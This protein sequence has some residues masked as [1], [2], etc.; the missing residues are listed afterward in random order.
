MFRS[1]LDLH[2]KSCRPIHLVVY[3]LR[4]DKR[5][6]STQTCRTTRSYQKWEGSKRNSSVYSFVEVACCFL[7]GTEKLAN[8]GDL[9]HRQEKRRK[10]MHWFLRYLSLSLASWRSVSQ[11]P[12]INM[13][14]NNLLKIENAQCDFRPGRSTTGR[15]FNLQKLL[16]KFLEYNKT[17]A[18]VLRPR[19]TIRAIPCK[20]LGSVV[21]VWCWRQPVT[22]RQVIVFQLRSLYPYPQSKITS[23]QRGC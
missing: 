1:V 20:A 19:E 9:P 22:G 12:W 3:N 6:G 23:V 11:M 4:T 10:W 7:E 17:S 21:R 18:H 2:V 13:P 15:I 5:T 8:W 14:R 16:E